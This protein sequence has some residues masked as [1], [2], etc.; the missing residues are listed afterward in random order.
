MGDQNDRVALLRKPEDTINGGD[1]INVV[2]ISKRTPGIMQDSNEMKLKSR[3]MCRVNGCKYLY[4]IST[5]SRV[6]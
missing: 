4:T 3:K 5:S 2:R 6:T 1:I